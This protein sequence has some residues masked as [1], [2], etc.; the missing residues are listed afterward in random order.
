MTLGKP[1]LRQLFWW[2]TLLL[3]TVLS[4]CCKNVRQAKVMDAFKSGS[5]VTLRCPAEVSSQGPIPIEVSLDADARTYWD[6][7]GVIDEALQ[8]MLVRTDRPGL[9]FVAKSD[10]AAMMQPSSPLPGRPS[11][12]ELARSPAHVVQ[13]NSYDVLAYG[14]Q[15]RGAA[16]YFVVAA[17]SDAWS[18]PTRLKV[19]DLD[20]PMVPEQREADLPLAN[21]WNEPI[22][23]GHGVSV[24]IGEIAG[25]PAVF[26]AFRTNAAKHDGGVPFATIVLARLGPTGGTLQR[27]FRLAYT[28][29]K[30]D[31]IGGF[32]VPLSTLD[33]LN[34]SVG[35][36]RYVVFAFVNGE[37]APTSLVQIP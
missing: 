3:L 31:V 35:P 21:Q 24:K 8:I 37:S 25:H 34:Q 12:E 1:I 30:E 4:A 29:D 2:S 22:P 23:A 28:R 11:V 27:Q 33:E 36:G 15:H 7:Q 10:P 17:F 16:E 18:G 9:L 14:R 5:A 20:G 32:V 13:K 26:G 6:N 19:V